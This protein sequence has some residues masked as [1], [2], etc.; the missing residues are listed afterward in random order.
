MRFSMMLPG[1]TVCDSL[2]NQGVHKATLAGHFM[3]TAV[4]SGGINRM[5]RFGADEAKSVFQTGALLRPAKS[6]WAITPITRSIVNPI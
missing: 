6:I 1:L 3:Q 5:T 2:T 4:Q